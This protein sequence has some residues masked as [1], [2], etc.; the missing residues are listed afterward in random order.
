M[1][2]YLETIFV[3]QE[4][5][6]HA[7]ARDIAK[8]MRIKMPSVTEALSRLKS[9]D[10]VNYD[11][12][13]SVTL[14]RKGKS[15][16]QRILKR[17]RVLCRFLREILGVSRKIAEEDACRIEHVISRQALNKLKEFVGAS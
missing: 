6:G 3:L 9:S 17:H 11:R 13:S 2:N 15:I 5:H 7:H 14:N 16:A 10:L 1:E 8:A 4:E 12:Y